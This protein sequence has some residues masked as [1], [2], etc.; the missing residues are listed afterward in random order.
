MA[1]WRVTRERS[2]FR[3]SPVFIG[4]VALWILGGVMAWNGFGN[5]TVNVIIFIFAGWIVSLALHEYA[6]ALLAY[7]AGDHGVAARGYLT[8]NPLKYAHPILSIVLPLVFLLLGGFGLPGGAVWVDRHAARSKGVASMIS[9]AGPLT[10]VAFLI[11]LTVPF[12]LGLYDPAHHVFWSALAFLAFLQLTAAVLNLAPIPGVDGGNALRPWLGEVWGRR[13]DL[14]APYGMLI[15]FVLIFEPR[16]NA[17]F[18]FIIDLIAG[19]IG[20]PSGLYFDG[21]RMVQFWN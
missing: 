1:E 10:N 8:L 11:L 19:I 20:L 15:L 18:F 21:L 16:V 14:V 17:I 6:H 9:L 2:A 5:A 7:R 13:F 4:I 3:P 12:Q